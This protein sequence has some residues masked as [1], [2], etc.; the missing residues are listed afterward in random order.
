MPHWLLKKLVDYALPYLLKWLFDKLSEDNKESE[1]KGPEEIPLDP[2]L[3]DNPSSLS[4]R[5]R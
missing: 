4:S 5:E 1:K 2:I 3:K